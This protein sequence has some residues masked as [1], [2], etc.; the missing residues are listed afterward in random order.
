[1]TKQMA[2]KRHIMARVISIVVAFVMKLSIV[3][4]FVLK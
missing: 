2:S 3:L 1:M 4:A